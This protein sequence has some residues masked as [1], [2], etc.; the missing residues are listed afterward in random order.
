MM[1][2]LK[3]KGRPAKRITISR[4][5]LSASG[6]LDRTRG[7]KYQDVLMVRRSRGMTSTNNLSGGDSYNSSSFFDDNAKTVVSFGQSP[8]IIR[9]LANKLEKQKYQTKVPPCCLRKG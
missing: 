6:T 3:S 2:A 9:A 7:R 8:A 4:S 5:S 1:R